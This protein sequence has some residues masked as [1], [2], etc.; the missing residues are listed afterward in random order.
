MI[1]VRYP[2]GQAV[3]YNTGWYLIRDGVGWHIYDKDPATGGS[4]QASIQLSAGCIVEWTPACRVENAALTV[5]SAAQLLAKH[6]R[7]L[8]NLSG[9][10]LS[11]LKR[12]LHDFNAKRWT[13]K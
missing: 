3:T 7:E 1:T 12:A 10:V 8:R 4:L 13:W 5:E 9:G 11:D 6:P 2:N